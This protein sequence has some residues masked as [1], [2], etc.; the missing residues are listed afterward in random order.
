MTKK[1]I[2]EHIIEDEEGEAFLIGTRI[3][4][5]QIVR[6]LEF[7]SKTGLRD[8]QEIVD[9]YP[10]GYVTLAKVYA[11]L[12][13]FHDNKRKILAEF[14]RGVPENFQFDER[15]VYVLKG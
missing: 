2:C 6:I 12:V 8:V 9:L 15:G 1:T 5:A 13:Y 11:A 10:V 4:V 3:S 14:E 7:G